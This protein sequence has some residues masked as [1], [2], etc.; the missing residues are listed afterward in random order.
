MLDIWWE[1]EEEDEDGNEG[2]GENGDD[3]DSDDL[4]STTP[5]EDSDFD[6]VSY[7][8]KQLEVSKIQDKTFSRFSNLNRS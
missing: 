7:H 8:V 6:E 2:S 1:T 5:D 4:S 3:T